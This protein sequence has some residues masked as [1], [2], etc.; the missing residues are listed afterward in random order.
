MENIDLGLLVLRIA[1]GLT[2]APHGAQKLFGWFGG[3]GVKGTGAWLDSMGAKYGW[4]IALLAGIAELFGGLGIA[5]GILT[6]VAAAAVV[7]VMLGAIVT[8]HKGKGFFNTNGGWEFPLLIALG[9]FALAITG[10]G[11]Y[12]IDALIG[13]V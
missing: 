11:T 2:I 6:P 12:S 5:L 10:P 7:L 3:Y 4:V 1:V 9:A 13:L 8:A